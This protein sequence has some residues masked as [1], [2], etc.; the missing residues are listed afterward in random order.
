MNRLFVVL[1]RPQK[2]R[3]I[4]ATIYELQLVTGELP[5][6]IGME[7]YE[8]KCEWDESDQV[9]VAKV[10]NTKNDEIVLSA[11]ADMSGKYSCSIEFNRQSARFSKENVESYLQEFLRIVLEKR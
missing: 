3:S 6:D 11:K 7:D 8:I 4:S 2:S 1:S 5:G 9:C 10:V